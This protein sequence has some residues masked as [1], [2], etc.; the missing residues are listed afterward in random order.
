[1][2]KLI[3]IHYFYL[4][5]VDKMSFNISGKRFLKI[6]VFL[7]ILVIIPQYIDHLT[8][9]SVEETIYDSQFFVSKTKS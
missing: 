6:L 2:S 8:E 3:F 7:W 9:N 5:F 4:F 1:M